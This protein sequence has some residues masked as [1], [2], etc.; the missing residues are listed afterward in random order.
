MPRERHYLK[1]K[2]QEYQGFSGRYD[3]VRLSYR[4]CFDHVHKT[5]ACEKQPKELEERAEAM[6][7]CQR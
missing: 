7:D 3:A 6:A 2:T 4:E 5:I 1:H